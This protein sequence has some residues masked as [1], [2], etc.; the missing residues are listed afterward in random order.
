MGGTQRL[1][2]LVGRGK[3]ME[4]CP[5]GRMIEADEAERIGLIARVVPAASLMEDVMATA[6][7][8]A[9]MPQEVVVL[10]KSLIDQC[11]HAGLGQ[12]LQAER[13][14]FESLFIRQDT[15]EGVTAF[16]QK[17]TPNFGR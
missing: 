8:I 16:L 10:L 17:R 12:G 6:Q 1:A 11:D 14:V 5:T 4:L 3:A 2:R 13:T 7:Q 9:A 15:R